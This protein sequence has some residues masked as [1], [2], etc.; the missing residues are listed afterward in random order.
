MSAVEWAERIKSRL[1]GAFP[2]ATVKVRI[3]DAGSGKFSVTVVSEAFAGKTPVARHRLVNK[4][5]GLN[6][7]SDAE[8]DRLTCEAIHALEITAQA[9]S[10]V[11]ASS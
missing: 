2:G 6:A 10:D 4:A 9:P 8:D 3:V 1:L 5:V 7:G 11:E